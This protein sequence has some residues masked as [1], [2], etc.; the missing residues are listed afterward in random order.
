V[1]S[2]G[3]G[4]SGETGGGSYSSATA[5]RS[6][7]DRRLIKES[8]TYEVPRLAPISLKAPKSPD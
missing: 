3:A 2:A 5:Q 8:K 7:S 1:E 6:A 4:S